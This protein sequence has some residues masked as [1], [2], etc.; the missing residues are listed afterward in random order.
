ME[1]DPDFIDEN[2]EYGLRVEYVDG[3]GIWE[4]APSWSHQRAISRI[5]ASFRV[6]EGEACECIHES[7]VSVKFGDRVHKRP[8][9]AVWCRVPETNQ[10]SVVTLPDAVVEVISPGFETKDLELLPKLYLAAGVRDVLVYNEQRG[11]VYRF[12]HEGVAVVVVHASPCVFHLACGC[13]VTI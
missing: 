10:R 5:R 1:Y 13:D 11:A 4:H 2:K 12:T 8:D 9:I 6:R 3:V 7:D